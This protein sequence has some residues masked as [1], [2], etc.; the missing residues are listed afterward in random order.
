MVTVFIFDSPKL[1]TGYKECPHAQQRWLSQDP[2]VTRPNA[3]RYSLV[4]QNEL[5]CCE[6]G[7][8]SITSRLHNDRP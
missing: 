1:R 8:D 7:Q 3:Y 2:W 6:Y 5:C 4:M